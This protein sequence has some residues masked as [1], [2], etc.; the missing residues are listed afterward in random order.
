MA[1]GDKEGT[2]PENG[3]ENNTEETQ[4]DQSF[5][6]RNFAGRKVFR[7]TKN[8]RYGVGGKTKK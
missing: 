1:R 4:G 2:L 8:W 6:F 7:E 3:T 5:G